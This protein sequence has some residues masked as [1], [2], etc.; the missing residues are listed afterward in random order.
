[1]TDPAVPTSRD[2]LRSLGVLIAVN[3]VD[4]LGFAMVFPILPFYAL[5]LGATP[6]VIGFM[7]S[8]FPVAQLLSAPFWGRVSDR[9]GRRPALLIGLAASA[10]AYVV[11]A[12]SGH[13]WLLFLSR[14]VQGAGGGTT[15]VAQAYVTDT[16]RPS[17]RAQ[18]LGWLSAATGAGIAIGPVISSYSSRFG[19]IYPGLIA[20]SICIVNLYFAWRW[21][22]ETHTE[23]KRAAA[24]PNKRPV[25]ASVFD[26]IRNP[27]TPVSK[28]I[29]IYGVGML[30][31]T[32][33]TAILPLWLGAEMTIHGQPI[34]EKN[35]G[36]VYTYIAILSFLIR[37][38]LLG[39][40]VRRFGEVGTIRLGCLAL[41]VG[42]VAYPFQTTWMGLLPVMALIPLGAALIFPS[43]TS[44]MSR[45]SPA[46]R[47]GETMGVAQM[48]SGAAR[49]IAPIISTGL[50]QAYTHRTPFFV[51]AGLVILAS[52]L[53]LRLDPNAGTAESTPAPA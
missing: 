7:I 41:V 21:L 4:Q 25:W 27:S 20:A 42:F 5:R 38:V 31:F 23:A 52:M 45:F 28:M 50:F 2:H 15:G 37:I 12:F 47:V 18:A 33:L 46:D 39:P 17:E 22:P 43:T 51:A 40:T 30:G 34:D 10:L 26:V 11:F 16:V 36:P 19:S 53:V 24:A 44:L 35:I 3:A 14:F 29:W 49:V 48:F 1:M 6:L 32:F 8:S 9:Y 13:I